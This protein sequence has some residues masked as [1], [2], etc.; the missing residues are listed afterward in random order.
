MLVEKL[1]KVYRKYILIK[2]QIQGV[3]KRFHLINHLIKKHSYKSY[4]EI[5]V[6]DG[7]CLNQIVVPQKT[8]VDPNPRVDFVPGA[9]LKKM[10]SDDF[11][12][13]TNE[14][15][16]IIFIDGL[17]THEQSYTD[18]TNA[19]NHL[20]PGGTIIFHDSNPT[21]E[22]RAKSFKDGGVWSGDVYKT[23]I[24][25]NSTGEYVV[26]TVDID[27]GCAVIKE[28]KGIPFESE[29]NYNWFNNNRNKALN[30]VSW[31]DFINKK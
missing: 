1:K 11:F 14:K 28:G 15:F 22:E 29:L 24:K 9:T 2:E 18:F 23:I 3:K 31:E 12:A 27:C 20:N 4:L 5:G 6:Q 19:V 10:T 16:D 17:H 7:F 21:T 25:I 26:N 8:G 30:L 13:S